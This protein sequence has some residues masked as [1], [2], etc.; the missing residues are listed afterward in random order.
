M[1]PNFLRL[2]KKDSFM[3][4]YEQNFKTNP[5]HTNMFICVILSLFN[6]TKHIV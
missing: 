6:Q 5:P 3:A 1:Y 2:A 4:Q